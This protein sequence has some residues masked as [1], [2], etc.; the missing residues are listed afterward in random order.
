MQPQPSE[1]HAL[2]EPFDDHAKR[3]GIDEF[4][5]SSCEEADVT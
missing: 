5:A 2:L 4:T 3:F 1:R